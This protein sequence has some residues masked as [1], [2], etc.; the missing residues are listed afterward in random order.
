MENNNLGLR[1]RKLPRQPLALPKLDPLVIKLSS[2]FI[3]VFS[4]FSL[5]C[6]FSFVSA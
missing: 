5:M 3:R 1:F 4:L 2:T 6:F